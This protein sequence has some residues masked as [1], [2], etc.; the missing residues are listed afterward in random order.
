MLFFFFYLRVK[1]LNTYAN[2]Q[3]LEKYKNYMDNLKDVRKL[4]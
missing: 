1:M 2:I 4:L 3:I